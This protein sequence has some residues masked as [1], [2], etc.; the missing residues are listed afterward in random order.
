MNT[1]VFS[2]LGVDVAGYSFCDLILYFITQFSDLT[3]DMDN[4]W[5]L[6]KTPCVHTETNYLFV[7]VYGHR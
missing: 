5:T 7:L 4:N 2:I 1:K 6:L 3:C